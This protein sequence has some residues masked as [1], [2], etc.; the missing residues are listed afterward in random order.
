MSLGLSVL[1]FVD[2][3]S[4]RN[5]VIVGFSFFMGMVIPKWIEDNLELI[6]TGKLLNLSMCSSDKIGTNKISI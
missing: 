5:L 2:L 4:T 6:N 3:N 1:Q